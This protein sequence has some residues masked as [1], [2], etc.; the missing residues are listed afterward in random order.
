MKAQ[1][2][3]P[4]SQHLAATSSSHSRCRE[5]CQS[6]WV[7]THRN[8]VHDR[9][10]RDML[11]VAPCTKHAGR[12]GVDLGKALLEISN[13]I[14]HVANLLKGLRG[15]IFCRCY[16]D[17]RGVA[18]LCCLQTCHACQRVSNSWLAKRPLTEIA[19]GIADWPGI[20]L[21]ITS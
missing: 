17:L 13:L 7:F 14:A 8:W 1:T 5:D 20:P 15:R 18:L 19:S 12:G 9:H 16:P 2:Q 4:L 6:Q 3:L 10:H 21:A 11:P